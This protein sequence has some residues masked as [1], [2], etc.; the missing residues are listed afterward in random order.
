MGIESLRKYLNDPKRIRKQKKARQI[1]LRGGKLSFEDYLFLYPD[2]CPKCGSRELIQYESNVTNFYTF[3][4]IIDYSGFRC[5]SKLCKKCNYLIVGENK[6]NIDIGYC[7]KKNIK[8]DSP[9]LPKEQ[10]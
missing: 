8:V 6:K 7:V 2:A 1:I 3:E 9:Y 4:W 10:S 5:S